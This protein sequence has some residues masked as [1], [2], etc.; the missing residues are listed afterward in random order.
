MRAIIQSVGPSKA[1]SIKIEKCRTKLFK[2]R[3]CEL[4]EIVKTLTVL[5]FK[6]MI[7]WQCVVDKVFELCVKI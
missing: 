4:S 1:L 2:F 3:A 7:I 6:D 5:D